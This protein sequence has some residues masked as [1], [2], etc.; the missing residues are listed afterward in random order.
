MKI[1]ENDLKRLYFDN[2]ASHLLMLFEPELFFL[3]CIPNNV[4]FSEQFKYK[5]RI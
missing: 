2:V 3:S 5:L 1:V 4:S